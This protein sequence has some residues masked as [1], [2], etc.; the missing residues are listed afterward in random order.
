MSLHGYADM[1]FRSPRIDA[2]RGAIERVVR[3][4]MR[5]L[6]L[7]TGLGTYATFAAR[8]GAESVTAVDSHR[9]V[10]LARSLATRNGLD[11]RID[12]V[13]ARAPEGLSGGPWDVIVF[14]DY[15]T[16]FLD[17]ATHRLLRVLAARHLVP[18]G[19]MLPGGVRFGMAA[20]TGERW[21]VAA[22]VPPE[23]R[24]PFGIDW[25]ELR[26]LLA[27]AGRKVFLTAASDVLAPGD[28]GPRRPL[29][30]VP[31][32]EALGVEGAWVASGQPVVGLAVWFDLDLGDGVWV[33]NAPG[34][35][36]EP[37]G[38]WLLPVDPPLEAP[39]GTT[40]RARVWREA[41]DEGAPGWTGW[42]CEAGGEV[43]RGHEFAGLPVA[44]GELGGG[45]DG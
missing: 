45:P 12:F 42:S 8:A 33:G 32:S 9:V 25:G 17:A 4:G 20:V 37:W 35:P 23:G 5:V 41:L 22:S 30:P 36:G 7:G 10:H 44:L 24:T 18:G 14:E 2:F 21:S 26:S 39:A 16:P 38:Q 27:N 3:P 34:G 28:P 15:P 40:I 43:R 19:V 13:R 29:L 6:D 31:S 1:V 11:D